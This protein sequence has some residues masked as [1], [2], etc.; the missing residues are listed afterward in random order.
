[1]S[2]QALYRTFRP[3]TLDGLVRQEHIVK[4]LTNQIETGRIGHAYLFCGPRGTGK[5]STAKIF[6]KAINCLSPVHGSPCG[7][8]EACK[9]LADPSNLDVSEIDAASNNGVNEMRDLREKVQYPPVA[10]RYK[11]YI[12][13]EVHMLSDSAFNALLK[14]LEEPPRHAVFILATT[15]PHKLPATIL[16]RCMRF[17]FKLIPQADIEAHLKKIFTSVGKEYEDEAVAAIARAGAGSM[18]DSLS[19]ADM[20]I[21]YGKGKL[22]YADVCE[23]LGTADFYEVARLGESVLR[24]DASAAL[25]ETEKV[26]SSGKGVGV[27]SKDILSFLNQCV[28][29]KT[30]RNAKELLALPDEMFTEIK[31]IAEGADGKKILRCCEIFAQVETDLRYSVSPRIVFETAVAKA[32]LPQSDTDVLALSLRVK[33]LEQQLEKGVPVQAAAP[34]LSEE[35]E[36][37][38]FA[39][40]AP[41]R[42][43]EPVRAAAPRPQAPARTEGQSALDSRDK[44]GAL[45]LRSLRKTSRSGV[46]FTMCQDLEPSFEGD[47]FVLST[48]SEVICSRLNSTENLKAVQAALEAIGISDFKIVLKG[49]QKDPMEEDIEQLKRDFPDTEFRIK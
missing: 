24:E 8:C 7:K 43:A 30:C 25:S 17:D 42:R 23:V 46:L 36:E 6:A 15:E 41:A 34:V 13:D 16:S 47:T 40:P 20:C 27:L 29:A 49:E 37:D 19:V 9:A 5:T 28:I 33:A 38:P 45:F 39:R 1:M 21:S 12:I 18:R 14:T 11:V 32:C 26:I 4:I 48:E 35:T 31:R 3:T 2:Y 10:V 44:A 22:T